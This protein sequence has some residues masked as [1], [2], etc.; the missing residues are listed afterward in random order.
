MGARV[1]NGLRRSSQVC[2]VVGSFT[3]CGP[4]GDGETLEESE[5]FGI[6]GDEGEVVVFGDGLS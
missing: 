4:V 1:F 2:L 5:V 3:S 6:G